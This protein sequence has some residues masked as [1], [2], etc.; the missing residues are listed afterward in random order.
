MLTCMSFSKIPY[1]L[2]KKS[3][4]DPEGGGEEVQTPLGKSQV[5][6]VSIENSIMLHLD[7][8]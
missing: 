1:H 3:C 5:I 2:L 4:A 6:W 7:L 8:P